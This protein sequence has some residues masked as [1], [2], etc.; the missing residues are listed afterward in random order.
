[1]SM[2]KKCL[3]ALLLMLALCAAIS[4]SAC[5]K[6]DSGPQTLEDF[7]KNNEDIQKSIDSAATDSNVAVEI[8]G[9]EIIYT[10]DLANMEEYTEELVHNEQVVENLKNALDQSASTFEGIAASVQEATGIDGISTTVKY[11]YGDEEIASQTFEP[12]KSDADKG[13]DPDTDSDKDSD[14]KSEDNKE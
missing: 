13:G 14:D 5:K 8:K 1:M 3:T 11:V 6:G 9:N 7:A 12:S 10:F 4:M 2:R